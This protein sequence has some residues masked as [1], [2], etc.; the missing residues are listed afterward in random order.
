VAHGGVEDVLPQ[1]EHDVAHD[2]RRDPLLDEVGRPGQHAEQQHQAACQ[3]QARHAGLSGYGVDGAGN[4]DRRAAA[5]ERVQGE[6]GGDRSDG[7]PLGQEI[8]QD[9]RQQVAIAVLPVVGLALQAVEDEAHDG[10]TRSTKL[11]VSEFHPRGVQLG[12]HG[13]VL[14]RAGG[15]E[16]A[17]HRGRCPSNQAYGRSG[18]RQTEH[19]S[20]TAIPLGTGGRGDSSPRPPVPK[21]QPHPR[22]GA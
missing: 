3:E 16:A 22:N 19:G 10:S 9:A 1:A 15:G 5:G 18:I 21:P 6:G 8:G 12:P 20:P 17:S 2:A 7:A 14:H 4:G 13:I 11:G